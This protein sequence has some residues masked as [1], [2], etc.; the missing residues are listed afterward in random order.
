MKSSKADDQRRVVSQ[1]PGRGRPDGQEPLG[2]REFRK[3]RFSAL[4]DAALAASKFNSAASLASLN[5][6]GKLNASVASALQSNGAAMAAISASPSAFSALANNS[7]ALQV[8]AK[9][10]SALA[11]LSNNSNFRQLMELCCLRLGPAVG[12]GYC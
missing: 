8:L 12:D 11:A 1:P 7:A 6:D 3:S 4:A 2:L 9:N 10:G 5:A